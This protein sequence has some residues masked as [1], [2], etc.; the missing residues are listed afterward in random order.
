MSIQHSHPFARR[1]TVTLLAA[2]SLCLAGPASAV[3]RV[4]SD[5]A[6]GGDGGNWTSEAMP[7]QAALDD[8][9]CTEVW[10]KAG[11]HVPGADSVFRLGSDTALYGGFAGTEWLRDQRDPALHVTVLSGDLN[12]DD[13]NGDGNGIAETVADIV[14]SNSSHVIYMVNTGG[15][16]ITHTTVVDGFTITAGAA[17]DAGGG[18]LCAASGAQTECSPIISNV[19]FSG[20]SSPMGGALGVS[21]TSGSVCSPTI[22]N[23]TF[24]GNRAGTGGALWV[25]DA[26]AG[27][28]SADLYNVTFHDN[29]I[30]SAGN[31]GGAI[32]FDGTAMNIYNATFSANRGDVGSAMFVTGG[33]VAVHD[34]IVWGNTNLSTARQIHREAG[35][36]VMI[37]HSVVEDAFPGGV[38]DTDLG[39]DAGGNSREEP[40][41]GDFDFHG[42]STRTRLLGSGSSAVDTGSIRCLPPGILA[43]DQRGMARPQG[44]LCDIGAVEKAYAVSL[45]VSSVSGLGEVSA[46]PT[47]APISGQISDCDRFSTPAE[48]SADYA[49]HSTVRLVATPQPLSLFAGWGGD[50]SGLGFF[51]DVL[52]DGPKSCTASFV[53]DPNA[54]L[55]VKLDDVRTHAQVGDWLTYGIAVSNYSG[56]DLPSVAVSDVLPPELNAETAT[57]QCLP[58]HD[59]LCTPSGS[60]D[61]DD[62]IDMPGYS[63]VF[64]VLTAQVVGGDTVVNQV[65][66]TTDSGTITD[67]DTTAIVLF[68]SGFES[69]DN[70]QS[71]APLGTLSSVSG[72]TLLVDPGQPPH[73]IATLAKS[74]DGSLR[75]ESVR[76]G[77]RTWLRLTT[78]NAGVEHR[79]EWSAVSTPEGGIGLHYQVGADGSRRVRLTGTQQDLEL[80]APTAESLA[81]EVGG[82]PY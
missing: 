20:N 63:S 66:A 75:V 2:L 45:L 76:V 55:Q 22:A 16:P 51:V 37:D 73:E 25:R 30:D 69:A 43:V 77:E 13:A 9:S 53:V 48:C 70:G 34:S 62:T 6:D 39:I 46:R 1:G 32:L 17:S 60:G 4:T 72:V 3:C 68:R 40:H 12:G 7:L 33:S 36:L 8:P 24:S 31:R 47:P 82:D 52:M 80:P 42:G 81:L 29:Y 54:D 28:A 61:L 65:G 38:W 78:R 35:A 79:S 27:I 26:T 14:G 18:L 56:T 67:T 23:V 57:W 58:N 5:A 50:C 49:Q 19:A 74:G 44:Q 41:L 21:A 71:G 10:V 15:A 64:Y 11:I 59:A